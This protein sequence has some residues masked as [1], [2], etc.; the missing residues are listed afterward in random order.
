MNEEEVLLD[1]VDESEWVLAVRVDEEGDV[2]LGLRSHC[3]GGWTTT[4][5]PPAQEA[6]DGVER[7]TWWVIRKRLDKEGLPVV[8]DAG[9]R[10]CCSPSV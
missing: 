4:L 6:E 2:D 7:N 5:V 1:L 10:A 9:R 8:T 3:F